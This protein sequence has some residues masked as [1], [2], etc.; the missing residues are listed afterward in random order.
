[1]WISRQAFNLLNELKTASEHKARFFEQLNQQLARENRRLI[2]RLLA[3]NNVPLVES[4]DN[5]IKQ[6]LNQP[7]QVLAEDLDLFEDELG[8]PVIPKDSKEERKLREESDTMEY[9]P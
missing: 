9:Q 4:P 1:M 7:D 2:E 6:V 5:V 3:K 8:E